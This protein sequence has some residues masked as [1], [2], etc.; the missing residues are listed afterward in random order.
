MFDTILSDTGEERIALQ[1]RGKSWFSHPHVAY[2]SCVMIDSVCI[3]AGLSFMCVE[4]GI[5]EV[6]FFL[7]IISDT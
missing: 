7:V 5:N 4:G 6:V 1:N 2:I 3:C